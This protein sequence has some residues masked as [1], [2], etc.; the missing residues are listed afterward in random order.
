MV[1]KGQETRALS[2]S[3]PRASEA[4]VSVPYKHREDLAIQSKLS[5]ARLMRDREQYDAGNEHWVRQ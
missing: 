5:A 2:N 3:M 4:F 1:S